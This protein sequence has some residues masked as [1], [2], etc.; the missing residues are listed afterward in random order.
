MVN[1]SLDECPSGAFERSEWKKYV[2]EALGAAGNA[3]KFDGTTRRVLASAGTDRSIS[4]E[5][6]DEVDCDDDGEMVA[7]GLLFVATVDRVGLP[8]NFVLNGALVKTSFAA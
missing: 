4:C 3:V 1:S 8:D 7:A 6:D 5:F 2:S